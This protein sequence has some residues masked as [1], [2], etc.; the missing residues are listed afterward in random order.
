MKN[1]LSSLP[2]MLAAGLE[3]VRSVVEVDSSCSGERV[4]G[5]RLARFVYPFVGTGALCLS[6]QGKAVLLWRKGLPDSG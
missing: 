3:K 2:M 5:S 4:A 1:S 6:P